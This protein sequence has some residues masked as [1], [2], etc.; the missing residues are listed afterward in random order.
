MV[1]LIMIDGDSSLRSGRFAMESNQLSRTR[2]RRTRKRIQFST[3]VLPDGIT[4]TIRK[5]NSEFAVF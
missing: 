3:I 4:Y 2:N 5:L 1:L